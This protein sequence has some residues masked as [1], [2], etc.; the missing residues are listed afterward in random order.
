[1]IEGTDSSIHDF[2]GC[3][4]GL[5]QKFGDSSKYIKKPWRIVSWNVD[6]GNSAFIEMRW[7]T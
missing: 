5:R 2:D 1:M 6:V 7:K 4:Y 3:C